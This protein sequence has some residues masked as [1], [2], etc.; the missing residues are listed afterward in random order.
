MDLH[1]EQLKP[2]QIYPSHLHRDI[3]YSTTPT[4]QQENKLVAF[5]KVMLIAQ[6]H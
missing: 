6:V 2:K 3:R 4:N 5:F 1:N